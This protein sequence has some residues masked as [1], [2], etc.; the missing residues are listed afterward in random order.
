MNA[1]QLIV[2]S[3]STCTCDRTLPALN[4]ILFALCHLRHLVIGCA[5]N[6]CIWEARTGVLLYKFTIS[7]GKDDEAFLMSESW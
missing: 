7:H 1:S 5:E 3:Y 2:L 4:N 6:L